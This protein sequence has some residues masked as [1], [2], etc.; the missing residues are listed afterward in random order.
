MNTATLAVL[1]IF[2]IPIIA[3]LMGGI[4]EILKLRSRQ[5]GV[6]DSTK[7][8]E[9]TVDALTD[10]LRALEAERDDLQQRVENLEAIVTAD[11]WDDQ[12]EADPAPEADTPIDPAQST[13][14]DEAPDAEAIARLA[15]R[16]R[17]Q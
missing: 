10:R 6:G 4:Q 3:I 1:L 16:L 14:S 9:T 2:S 12:V 8:L 13:E 15:R 17:S 11:A 7:E 5:Q